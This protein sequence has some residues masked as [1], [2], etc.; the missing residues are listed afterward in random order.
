MTKKDTLRGLLSR[1]LLFLITLDQDEFFCA[2]KSFDRRFALLC[3]PSRADPLLIHDR[4]CAV[5]SSIFRTFSFLMFL[6]TP[7]HIIGHPCIERIVR[8]T[9]DIDG[10]FLFG[11]LIDHLSG[12]L[13]LPY[14]MRDPFHEYILCAYDPCNFHQVE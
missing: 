14:G 13:D 5:R 3:F 6:E 11:L 8:T 12:R 7:T 1:D 2:W 4:F 10:I 9:D